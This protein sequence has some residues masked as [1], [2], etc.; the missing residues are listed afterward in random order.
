MK[1]VQISLL[2]ER[3]EKAK[4]KQMELLRGPSLAALKNQSSEGLL[5]E[6]IKIKKNYSLMGAENAKIDKRL[7][8]FHDVDQFESIASDLI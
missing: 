3:I 7:E 2:K 1:D 4:A 8:A 6:L 5:M